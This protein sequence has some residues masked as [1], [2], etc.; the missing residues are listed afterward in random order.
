MMMGVYIRE[1]VHGTHSLTHDP[2]DHSMK[3]LSVFVLFAMFT[4]MALAPPSRAQFGSVIM[5]DSS[6]EA[7]MI[8][9]ETGAA[10]AIEAD[11]TVNLTLSNPGGG[12]ILGIVAPTAGYVLAIGTL[13]V[14]SVIFGSGLYEASIGLSR[15]CDASSSKVQTHN[16]IVINLTMG[17]TGL[18]TVSAV[19][20]SFIF[21]VSAGDHTFCIT[22]L[23]TTPTAE[24][25]GH[26]ENMHLALFFT[27]T[28]YGVVDH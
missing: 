17:P 9:N 8:L 10:Q 18:N 15:D 5:P 20:L 27:P 25:V 12:A 2:G 16:P 7:S 28:A 23:T 26:M 11:E 14:H 21:T 6:I 13:E 3:R 22:G 19:S 4:T 1:A 24:G